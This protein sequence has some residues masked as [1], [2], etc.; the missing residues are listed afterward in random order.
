MRTDLD[1]PA[2]IAAV[3]RDLYRNASPAPRALQSLRPFICPFEALLPWVPERGRMLDIGC[4]AGLF[5][6]LVAQARP[7]ITA[8][9]F[10]A[11]RGAIAAAQQMALEHF[12]DERIDFRYSAVEEAWPARPFDAVSIVDVLH[13]IPVDGQRTVVEQALAHVA[14]GGVLI[15]KDMADRPLLKAG[16]NR[17]HD[18]VMARQWIRY[19]PIEEVRAWVEQAGGTVIHRAARSMGPYAHELLVVRQAT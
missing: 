7:Q 13:H 3:A 2:A 12:G 1:R 11:S 17:L 6:G 10:D 8:I 15:Y 19:R 14:P 5:L 16:W 9:G 4:G 18:L